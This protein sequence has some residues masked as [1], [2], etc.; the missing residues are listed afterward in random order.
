MNLISITSIGKQ[1]WKEGE[2][3][4]KPP[5]FFKE[6]ELLYSIISTHQESFY[7]FLKNKYTLA[8]IIKY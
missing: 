1:T 8:K 3:I 5:L 2:N 4:A 7:P 6:R